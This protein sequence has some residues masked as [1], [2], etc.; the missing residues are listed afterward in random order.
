[1]NR[2]GAGIQLV[3]AASRTGKNLADFIEEFPRVKGYRDYHAMLEEVKPDFVSIC[4]FPPDREEMTLAALSAGAKAIWIEKP[5]AISMG[6]A[7]RMILAAEE[8]GARLFVN[9]QRRFGRPFEWIQDSVGAGRIGDLIGVQ[10]SQPGNEFINFGPHLVDAALNIIDASK[11][12]RAVKVF[13]AVEWSEDRYQGIAAESQ[14][15]GTVHFSDGSRM[16]VEAG[17][18]HP[19]LPSVIRFD[20]TEG[21]AELRLSPL[22]EEPGIARGHFRGDTGVI[23]LDIDENFHHGAIDKNLYVDRAL[24]DIL[25]ALENG[26]SSRIDAAAV[27]PGLEIMLALYES[28]NQGKMIDLPL[29]QQES[30][31]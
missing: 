30:P 3:A 28:A 17:R 18:S 20:G 8:H 24:Q 7:H 15:A 5:F 4:A 10:I 9:F 26:R 29:A 1:M 19:A 13:A 31:F 16:V 11:N 2:E 14:I 12:R 25:D 27:L 6:A 22:S 21:F 23:V